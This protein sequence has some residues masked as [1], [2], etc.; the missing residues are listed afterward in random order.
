MSKI[1][2]LNIQISK[3]LIF[4]FF[5]HFSK[6]YD[7][8]SCNNCFIVK[9]VDKTCRTDLGCITFMPKRRLHRD[10]ILLEDQINF[11]TKFVKNGIWKFSR[12]CFSQLCNNNEVDNLTYKFKFDSGDKNITR[13]T[14]NSKGYQINGISFSIILII[15]DFLLIFSN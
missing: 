8:Y 6:S 15:V 9:P 5:P 11:S 10:C 1:K 14:P 12:V 13:G 4:F 7:C 2:F 3:F